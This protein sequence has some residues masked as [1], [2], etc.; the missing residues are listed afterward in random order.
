H[1]DFLWYLNDTVN[2]IREPPGF[3][4]FL[5]P[6]PF[7]HLLQAVDDDP[8]FIVNV[9]DIRSDVIILRSS[10]ELEI[11]NLPDT[12]IEEISGI[13]SMMEYPVGR[14]NGGLS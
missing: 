11:V 1:Q 3:D 6:T 5:R 4:T 9:N 2:Q 12:T 14:K 8:V 7:H 10:V 13:A